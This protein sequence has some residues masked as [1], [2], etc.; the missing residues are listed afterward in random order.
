MNFMSILAQAETTVIEDVQVVPLDAIWS[1]ITALTWLQAVIAVS[2]GI[3]YLLY[4][5]RIFRI[6]VVICFGLIGMY[7]GIK[8][9]SKTG[10]EVW[11]G[12]IGLAI[13]AGISAPLMKWCVSILGA[14]AGG[15]VTGGLW[16]AFNLPQVY[17][18]AGAAVGVVAGGMMSFIVLKASV[19]L[20]T[21]LGGSLITVVGMLQLLN[22]YYK[23]AP[24]VPTWV[25]NYVY[26]YNW[27]LPVVLIVPTMIGMIAQNRFIKHSHKW[28]F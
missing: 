2:F 9:G 19:M 4:G 16:Y 24:E 10:S 20:F 6:L 7:L 5:W 28:E 17:L 18:W 3:V 12:V 21:S 26:N 23:T 8:L 15:L 14:A 22:L 13:F 11:G 27:F 1:Q 25:Q